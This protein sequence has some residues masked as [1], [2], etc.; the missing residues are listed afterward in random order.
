MS[1]KTN[2]IA[3]RANNFRIAF[4]M[5]TPPY[6]SAWT[7][8]R[9]PVT[10]EG[11][12]EDGPRRGEC[13]QFRGGRRA[14]CHGIVCIPS[15]VCEVYSREVQKLVCCSIRRTAPR[16]STVTLRTAGSRLASSRKG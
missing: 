6:F 16:I 9:R 14:T 5:A 7:A 8:V 4:V 15:F 13:N 2:K 12:D 11:K 3:T 1:T 10:L